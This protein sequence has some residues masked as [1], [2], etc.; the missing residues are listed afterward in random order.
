MTVGLTLA[1]RRRASPLH[2]ARAGCA[3]TYALGLLIA[4]V[5]LDNPVELVAL[6]LAIA[7]AA[8]LA[9]VGRDLRRSA[10]PMLVLVAAISLLNALISRN[11]LTVLARLGELPP[12]GEIDI[13]LEALVYGAVL[14]L[15]LYI[16][17]SVGMLATATVDPDDLLR[18]FRRVSMRSAVTAALATRIVPLLEADGRRLAEA[19]RCRPPLA[20]GS[21]RHGRLAVVRATATGAL[22]RA[23][24]IAATLEVRG[25]ALLRRP[26]RRRQPVSRHDLAFAASG[27]GLVALAAGARLAGVAAFTADPVLHVALGL[28]ELGLAVALLA[29]ALAPFADRRGID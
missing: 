5:V 4:A 1:Y 19:R 28:P 14:G 25:Y 23:L 13:T 17:V 27:A 24:D 3:A 12:F 16:A 15:Q 22:D 11:G 9:G 8:G 26:A 7:T 29:V 10:L 21:P 2:A 18:S 6:L 20:D